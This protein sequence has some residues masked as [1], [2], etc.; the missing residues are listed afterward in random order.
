MRKLLSVILAITLVCGIA[1]A[2]GEMLS[3]YKVKF[4]GINPRL[5]PRL[6]S[7]DE[8]LTASNIELQETGS[9][10]DRDLF[11]QYNSASGDLGSNYITGLFKYY[12]TTGKYFI[13]C[14]GS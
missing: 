5:N 11:G 6:L 14:A 1:F 2:A 12:K 13:A 8:A 7:D 9:F 3:L 4:L 10:R